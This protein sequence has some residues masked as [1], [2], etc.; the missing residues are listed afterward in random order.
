MNGTNKFRRMRRPVEMKQLEQLDY[1]SVESC[2][3]DD[4]SQPYKDYIVVK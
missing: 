1:D 2:S 4:D 3:D